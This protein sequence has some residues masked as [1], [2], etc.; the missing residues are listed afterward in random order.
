MRMHPIAPYLAL[1]FATACRPSATEADCA[2]YFTPYPDLVSQR[3]R[4][5]HNDVFVDGM[6]SY[7][8]EDYDA[9]I[10]LLEEFAAR[11]NADKSAH[12]YLACSYLATGRPYDAELELDHLERGNLTQF[13]DENAWY[14]VLCWLCSGQLDRA[15]EGARRIA[16]GGKHTYKA[17]AARLYNALGG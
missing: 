8:S 11:P 5:M 13:V 10:P 14:T 9:A 7:A 6:R 2:A 15:R 4:T 17:D 16:E 1:L 3:T 12:L